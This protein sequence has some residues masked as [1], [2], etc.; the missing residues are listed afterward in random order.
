MLI[1]SGRRKWD[2][3][4]DIVHKT[5]ISIQTVSLVTNKFSCVSGG[6]RKKAEAVVDP[7]EFMQSRL[8]VCEV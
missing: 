7:L 1:L 5:G 8:V 6:N 4:K 3:I 2:V